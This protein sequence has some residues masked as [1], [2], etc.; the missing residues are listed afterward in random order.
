MCAEVDLVRASSAALGRRARPP[1]AAR[2]QETPPHTPNQEH[3][4][5]RHQ[6][7]PSKQV[8]LPPRASDAGSIRPICIDERSQRYARR[9]KREWSTNSWIFIV[10]RFVGTF[11]FGARGCC[12]FLLAFILASN[13][14]H[15]IWPC[16]MKNDPKSSFHSSTSLYIIH[17]PCISGPNTCI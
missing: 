11:G 7:A 17:C 6:E 10:C 2:N 4:I 13:H 3:F 8:P 15:T 14:L 12:F 1:P 9:L 16:T 5:A